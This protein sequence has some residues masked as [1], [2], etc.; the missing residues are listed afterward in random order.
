MP[1]I[2]RGTWTRVFSVRTLINNFLQK[3]KSSS[4]QILS[5]GAGFDTNFF[6]YEENEAEFKENNVKYY[7]VDFPD[8]CA[9]KV[10]FIKE[11]ESMQSL[12]FKADTPIYEGE[13]TIQ[14]ARYKLLP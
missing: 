8:I 1:I 9:Q 4:V 7:E 12:I 5:L 13:D 2:N 11:N 3:Y 6:Y 14:A 10:N